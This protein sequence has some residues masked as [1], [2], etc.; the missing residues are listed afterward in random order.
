MTRYSQ[1]HDSHLNLAEFFS[2]HIEQGLYGPGE[3][4]P[5]VRTLSQEHRVSLT[6]VQ[7]AYRVLECSGL[8]MPRPKSGYFVPTGRRMPELS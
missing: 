2:S 7:Q 4:L 3:R 1:S 5:S 8:A 6:T